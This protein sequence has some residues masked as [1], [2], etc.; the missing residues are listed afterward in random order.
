MNEFPI[1]LLV[2]ILCAFGA[3][4]MLFLI[5]RTVVLW[6]FRLDEIAE[7]LKAIKQCLEKEENQS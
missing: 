2:A 7:T 1:F 6:Y 4:I 3:L 5:I